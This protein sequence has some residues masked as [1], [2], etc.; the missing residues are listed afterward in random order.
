MEVELKVPKL[1]GAKFETAIIERYR[2]CES[3]VEEALMEMY[4]YLDGISLKRTWG[5]EVRNVSV[6]VAEDGFAQKTT[7]PHFCYQKPQLACSKM[8]LRK[9]LSIFSLF[10]LIV[11]AIFV[12]WYLKCRV[13]E[14]MV[15]ERSAFLFYPRP[16][17]YMRDATVASATVLCCV[18]LEGSLYLGISTRLSTNF[19]YKKGH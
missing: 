14:A 8:G 16:F 6:F 3:A 2:R 15:L 11:S 9:K 18:S 17:R 13:R 7:K 1:R 4:V 19:R 10:F 5:G 12:N